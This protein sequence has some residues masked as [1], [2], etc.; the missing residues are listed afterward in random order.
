VGVARSTAELGVARSAN[1]IKIVCKLPQNPNIFQTALHVRAS[2]TR[3]PER[4]AA[5]EARG[6]AAND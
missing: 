6:R 3:H 2:A 1:A 5:Q 4:Y